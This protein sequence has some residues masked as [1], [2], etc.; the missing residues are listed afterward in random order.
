VF[1][2]ALLFRKN[3]AMF[4]L[5]NVLYKLTWINSLES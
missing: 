3:N 1:D 4:I 2:N 5:V